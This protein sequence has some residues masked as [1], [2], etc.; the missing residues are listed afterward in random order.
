M[1]AFYYTHVVTVS[2]YRPQR[3]V[4][5]KHLFPACVISRVCHRS[6]LHCS[7]S[8]SFLLSYFTK[9]LFETVLVRVCAAI[10]VL[11][12]H[13]SKIYCSHMKVI[14]S[15]SSGMNGS[16]VIFLRHVL[17]VLIFTIIVP[18]VH[19]VHARSL[20]MTS[21]TIFYCFPAAEASSTDGPQPHTAT[22]HPVQ[23]DPTHAQLRWLLSFRTGSARLPQLSNTHAGE[24]EPIIG[25]FSLHCRES[26]G[27]D[28]KISD[29]WM[30]FSYFSFR[31][32]VCWLRHLDRKWL[33]TPVFF[34]TR[35]ILCSSDLVLKPDEQHW[36]KC[37]LAAQLFHP[38]LKALDQREACVSAL[39]PHHSVQ[40][41]IVPPG[42]TW[43]AFLI[44][45]LHSFP[46][47]WCNVS[48]NTVLF[49]YDVI[50]YIPVTQN[51]S[52]QAKHYAAAL[53]FFRLHFLFHVVAT[54]SLLSG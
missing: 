36:I 54:Q 21:Q 34:K 43:I 26:T 13:L 1:Q 8:L 51:G 11:L 12:T 53:R 38:N 18:E 35:P 46:M 10:F 5:W 49:T 40:T 47:L 15:S 4:I 9:A 32:L 14:K 31:V 48:A 42:W 28:N 27:V 7:V 17:M 44:V 37:G 2:Y 6:T 45:K 19:L 22:P 23:P 24:K 30:Q 16:L 3:K 52:L 39:T 50:G 33:S 29:G 25:T 41:F 20:M